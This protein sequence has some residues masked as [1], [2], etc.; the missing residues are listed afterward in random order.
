MKSFVYT[1]LLAAGLLTAANAQSLYSIAGPTGLDISLPLKWNFNVAGGYDSNV[2]A[3]NW[4]EDES[5]FISADVRASLSNYD[6]ITQYS[7]NAK[8]GG[9]FYLKDLEGDSSE[10]LSN[11]SFSANLTHSFSQTL[12]MSC[13][14]SFAWQ[15][16]PNYANGVA[17]SRRDGEYIYAYVGTT[18]SKAWNNRYSTS[19]GINYSR[20][21][22]QEEISEIDNREYFGA[23]INNR[24][25]WT[26]R[27]ALSLAWRYNYCQRIWGSDEF[28]NFIFAGIEYALD[29]NTSA[30]FRVGPQF[31]YVEGYGHKTYPSA[32]FGLNRT[33][34][35]RLH[36]G[37]FVRYSNEAT[38]TY[39]GGG[40]RYYSNETWRL[41]ITSDYKLTPRFSI[42][43]GLNLI[44]SDYSRPNTT[45]NT[46][47]TT[48][49]VNAYA[50]VKMDITPH[51]YLTLRYS[52]TNGSYS[53]YS[54]D[55][56]SYD[57]NVI[58]FGT[59]YNF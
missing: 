29:E 5:A 21:D 56:P 46:D 8:L 28:S 40:S 44:N 39:V 57:R 15:P 4:D 34:T 58:S 11:S 38:N 49:T 31:K 25:K 19:F 37:A 16:E 53:G 12:R 7:L 6:S 18:L 41:G 59:G 10:N 30:T 45:T 48:L 20:I 26:E 42:M 24:Y 13:S 52:Y 54:Y 22:Y 35:D 27:M 9:I 50:G 43:A 47:T 17:N 55:M 1:S 14:A 33:V 32:E 51:W 23:E 2:N 36:L 3:S